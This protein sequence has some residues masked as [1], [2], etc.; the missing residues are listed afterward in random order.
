MKS[1]N[2]NHK[3]LRRILLA[4]L[5]ILAVGLIAFGIYVSDYYHADA[6]AAQALETDETVTVEQLDSGTMAFV[7]AKPAAGLIFYPGGKVEYTAYAPLLH[8]L[9]QEGILCVLVKMPCN[10]AV[11]DINAADGIREQFPELEV[12]YIGGHSLGGSMAASY[13]AKHASEYSGL[14]L[15]AAYS[16]ADLSGAGLRVVSLYGTED[17]VLNMEKYRG[18]RVNLPADT[19]EYVIEGGCHAQFGSYGAQEGDGTPRISAEEQRQLAVDYITE[20]IR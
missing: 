9:A 12:W 16:T 17:M 11:L 7:P 1:K 10:L 4:V 8:D 18:N 3:I 15:L 20:A 13:A 14:I 6:A 19:R 5:C 2:A